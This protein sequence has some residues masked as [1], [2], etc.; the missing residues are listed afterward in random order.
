M[1]QSTKTYNRFGETQRR[2]SSRNC[3]VEQG[4][5]IEPYFPH[6]DESMRRSSVLRVF[7]NIT[8]FSLLMHL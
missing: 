7:L 1:E 8:S 6:R 5:R 2:A 3:Y 4:Q